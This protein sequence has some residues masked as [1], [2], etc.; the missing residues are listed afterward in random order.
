MNIQ[1]ANIILDFGMLVL[2]WIVQLVIYPGFK[3]YQ[4]QDLLRWHKKYIDRITYIVMPLMIGQLSLVVVQVYM[5]FQFYNTIT[6]V[7]LLLFWASTFFQFVP[8]H[9]SISFGNLNTYAL[10]MLVRKNWIRTCI[11]TFVF[12][13]DCLKMAT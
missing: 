7:L 4:K 13:G 8:M 11:L 2:I 5:S 9:N 1:I 10:D 12:F 3:D 6:L